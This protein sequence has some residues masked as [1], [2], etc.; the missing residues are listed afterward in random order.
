MRD[1]AAD[2]M[3]RPV[4]TASFSALR[5]MVTLVTAA[6]LLFGCNGL[7]WDTVSRGSADDAPRNSG[8]EITAMIRADFV[9]YDSHYE[10]RKTSFGSRLHSL[11]QELAA[12]Q[13][14]GND[15]PCST[16]IYL[17]AQWLFQYTADWEQLDQKLNKLK[18]SLGNRD[19]SFAQQQSAQTHL[20]GICYE[21][22]FPQAEEAL[23]WLDKLYEQDRAPEYRIEFP[24][25]LRTS[26]SLRAYLDG[27]L[28]SDISATG[29]DNRGE[30]G[31]ITTSLSR[32][33]F[34]SH[35][36]RYLL[37][38]VAPREADAN[39]RQPGSLP[40]VYENFVRWWQDP[41]TGYWGPW[42]RFN[43]RTYKSADLSI[44][45]HIIVYRSG[46]VSYWPQI[47]ETTLRIKSEPYP[48]GWLHNGNL[49]NHNNY[50]VVRILKSGW[51]YMTGKQRLEA[52]K[53]IGRMLN[54]T[55]TQ[56]LNRDG[57]FK[58]DPTFFS[59]VPA[60]YYFGVSFLDQVGYWDV[61]N[62]FWT[63]ET[64][65]NNSAVCTLIRSRLL[66]LGL[67]DPQAMNALEK[68]SKYCGT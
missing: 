58:S 28:V 40:E 8:A 23:A 39:E 42:Y 25:R 5:L 11:A 59:S 54:W 68:L 24:E 56:S 60:D 63:S 48:F 53:E 27:L 10:E 12:L 67:K 41:Q 44:T 38:R 43:G 52:A 34:K 26:A 46:R 37:Q 4:R 14:S 32:V 17:E 9:R 22:W 15:M 3:P 61:S 2:M 35:F 50:D 33:F 55:L 6:T 36:H 65:A 51:P 21:E 19:Q 18:E 29:R 47:I 1:R 7:S 49:N 62:R 30:L 20:W 57:S 31:S 16:Q 64:F 66:A 45:Y 13:A